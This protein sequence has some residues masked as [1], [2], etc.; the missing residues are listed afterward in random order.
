[1]LDEQWVKNFRM[2]RE[3]FFKLVHELRPYISPDESSP[4]Y[5]ALTAEKRLAVALYY[6]KDTGSLVMTANTLGIAI[7]TASHVIFQV[8]QTIS[9]V[10]GPKYISLPETTSQM[11]QSV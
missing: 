10:L 1:M 9:S 5:R 2:T 7:C 3:E 11:R 6:L 8:C 4:N